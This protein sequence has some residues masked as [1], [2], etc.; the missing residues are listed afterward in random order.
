MWLNI[1]LSNTT[2]NCNCYLTIYYMPKIIKRYQITIE[3]VRS[4]YLRVPM[5]QDIRFTSIPSLII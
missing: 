2:F 3:V 4:K 1:L 5:N